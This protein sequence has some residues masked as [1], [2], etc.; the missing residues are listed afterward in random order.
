[1]QSKS[2]RDNLRDSRSIFEEFSTILCKSPLCLP[3]G[4]T[5]FQVYIN[6]EKFPLMDG[7]DGLATYLVNF[8]R[9]EYYA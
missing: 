1:M 3:Q 5:A 2:T 8:I 6:I 4:I 9:S 7:I